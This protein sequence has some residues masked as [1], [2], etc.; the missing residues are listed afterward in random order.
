MNIGPWGRAWRTLFGRRVR[1]DQTAEKYIPMLV[2]EGMQIGALI[3]VNKLKA[4]YVIAA[5]LER[6][7]QVCG[8]G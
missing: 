4:A 6:A 1:G 5:R 2:D 8:G 3:A 7:A